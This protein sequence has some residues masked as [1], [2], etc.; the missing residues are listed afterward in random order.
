[1]TGDYYTE[2]IPAD[3]DEDEVLEYIPP[4]KSELLKDEQLS[5]AKDASS[6]HSNTNGVL[7]EEDASITI[8]RAREHLTELENT[9]KNRL[10]YKGRVREDPKDK[11][12]E[13]LLKFQLLQRELTSLKRE[14]DLDIEGKNEEL[15]KSVDGLIDQFAD[16][17]ITDSKWI[18]YWNDKFNEMSNQTN[19]TVAISRADKTTDA[20][21]QLVTNFDSRVGELELNY[22]QLSASS[23]A[24]SLKDIIDD[25]Y[26]KVDLI[27][28]DGDGESI[29][30]IESK[31][32]KMLDQY[33][34]SVKNRRNETDNLSDYKLMKLYE[35][36]QEIPKFDKIIPMIYQRLKSIN[37]IVLQTSN[38]NQFLNELNLK[39]DQI[40]NQ[41]DKW[42]SKLE[43]LIKK[44]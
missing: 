29:N 42:D 13:R 30:E 17:K 27:I 28:K 12:N 35:R 41:I 14:I 5:R 21:A 20:E 37:S 36:V 9:L 44:I 33:E 4:R 16:V 15:V 26:R 10:L 31:F 43:E 25:L 11:L 18:T 19:E 24:I 34:D 6:L 3:E 40:E 23:S 22:A 8:P 7:I 1:M 38:S 2:E 39:L 32:S